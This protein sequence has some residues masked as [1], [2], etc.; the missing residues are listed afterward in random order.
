MVTPAQRDT[1]E[2]YLAL[3]KVADH[4]SEYINGQIDAM[5]GG[6][7]S[8]NMVSGNIRAKL[9]QQLEHRP[10]LVFDREMKVHSQET[11]IYTYPD[12]A[13]VCG[14]P[15]F[16]D[17]AR[18]VLANPATLF[19]VLSPSAEAHDRGAKFSHYPTIPSL[20][21]YVLVAQERHNWELRECTGIDSVV[22]L[23]SI[24]CR[25]MLREIYAKVSV[26]EV[27]QDPSR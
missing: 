6:T 20:Q 12:A 2:E 11:G 3:E 8:H 4:R 9:H 16:I 23:E 13:V 14:G 15:V 25:L 19:E 5:S 18:T 27:V 22:R 24:D 26:D 7:F 1:P 10:C 21:E 17:K